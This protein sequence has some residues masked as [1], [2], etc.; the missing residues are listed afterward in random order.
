MCVCRRIGRNTCTI[1]Q[2][3]DVV[4]VAV[5]APLVRS[6]YLRMHEFFSRRKTYIYSPNIDLAKIYGTMKVYLNAV[7]RLRDDCVQNSFTSRP[8]D[9]RPYVTYVKYVGC[10]YGYRC[11]GIHRLFTA[12]LRCPSHRRNHGLQFIHDM[13]LVLWVNHARAYTF[14]KLE[15]PL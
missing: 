2:L 6:S 13:L 7:A 9:R 4:V 10:R 15:N 5:A 1:Y 12:C 3:F 14:L 11:W 8:L